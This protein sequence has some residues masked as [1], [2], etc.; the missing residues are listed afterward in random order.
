MTL[1]SSE[2][3]YIRHLLKNECAI[4]LENGKEYLVDLRLGILA[5][6]EGFSSIHSLIGHLS[7]RSEP[8]LVKKVVDAMTTNETLFFRDHKPFELLQK[9]LLPELLQNR[10][11]SRELNIW[12]AASSTGQEPYSIAMLIHQHFPQLV[13]QWNLQILASDISFTCLE[14]AREAV[15]NQF[16]V[17]RGLPIQLLIRYFEQKDTR[18]QLKPEI[19][20][21][22]KFQELNL[23]Q[24]WPFLPKMDIIFLRNVLI[25]F[26]LDVKKK[27]LENVRK[28]LKPDGYLILGS[29]ETT[30]LID[31]AFERVET[32]LNVNC[33]RLAT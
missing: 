4:V 21:M 25:Y 12:S 3:D 29:A 8:D 18:W 23:I 1:S 10:A 5:D 7:K 11:S 20:N 26:D 17:N 15:Y 30:L 32:S 19:K 33:Y 14:Y 24:T 9:H 27:I 28:V 16:E 2:F 22:V 13:N 6:N 31:S